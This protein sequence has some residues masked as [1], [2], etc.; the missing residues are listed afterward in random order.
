MFERKL[1]YQAPLLTP[2]C[3]IVTA[4]KDSCCR[5]IEADLTPRDPFGAT[6]LGV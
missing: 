2:I 4:T 6:A 1:E 5:H 3:Q